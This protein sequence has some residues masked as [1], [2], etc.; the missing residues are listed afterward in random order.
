MKLIATSDTENV[1]LEIESQL[2]FMIKTMA[3][4]HV[5]PSKPKRGPLV[6]FYNEKKQYTIN[7]CDGSTLSEI[8]NQ[9]QEKRDQMVK[10]CKQLFIYYIIFRVI[11]SAVY[12]IWK[13]MDII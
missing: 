12:V 5:I 13:E 8:R 3:K 2:Y 4:N 10:M 6:V 9:L 1:E 11:A 7:I